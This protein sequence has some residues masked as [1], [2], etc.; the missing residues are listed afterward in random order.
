M[1]VK[2]N[3]YHKGLVRVMRR[4]LDVFD[5]RMLDEAIAAVAFA[6]PDI[7]GRLKVGFC[8]RLN[9]RGEV[10][11]P[12]SANR[13]I[14]IDGLHVPFRTSMTKELRGILSEGDLKRA[15]R[16]TCAEQGLISVLTAAEQLPCVEAIA[17][18]AEGV[19]EPYDRYLPPC[20]FCKRDIE[21]L[22]V[23]SG[24]EDSLPVFIAT[25]DRRSAIIKTT[26][27]AIKLI[28][29]DPEGIDITRVQRADRD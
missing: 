5:Q 26:F 15:L 7:L 27:G 20:K 4:E 19:E 3:V 21:K 9:C 13:E 8:V 16:F 28:D 14:G 11:Y 2:D 22:A 12:R 18:A 24:L 1:V 29:F 10:T 17:I 25:T 6:D 23:A